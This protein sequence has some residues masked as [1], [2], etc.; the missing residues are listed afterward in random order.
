MKT[1]NDHEQSE[2]YQQDVSD[3]TFI[4][5]G[6]RSQGERTCIAMS[7]WYTCDPEWYV[8]N[9]SGLCY[10]KHEKPRICTFSGSTLQIKQVVRKD[11]HCPRA[12][13]D[14]GGQGV[15]RVVISSCELDQ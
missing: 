3:G 5:G 15:C 10:P 8:S 11:A 7:V 4:Y 12:D 9:N 2:V 6:M 1:V 14:A 13:E